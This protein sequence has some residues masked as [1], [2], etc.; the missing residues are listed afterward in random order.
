[1]PGGADFLGLG[2]PTGLLF[3][4]QRAHGQD[5]LRRALDGHEGTAVAMAENSRLAPP[6]FGE[7]KGRKQRLGGAAHALKDRDI[8]WIAAAMARGKRR[9]AAKLGRS[10]SIRGKVMRE[11]KF[12]LGDG[13]GFVRADARD[14]ADIL[15]DHR[16]AHERLAAREAIDAD[17]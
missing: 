14:A 5:R 10:Y 3:W 1:M 17:A 13:A 6:I 7:G 16:A 8:D 2:E 4:V 15:D 11:R 9:N 12:A